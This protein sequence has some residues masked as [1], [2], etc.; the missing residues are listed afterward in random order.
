V[1]GGMGF[2]EETGAAQHMRDARVLAI[3]EGTNGIQANDLLFRKL[4]RDGGTAFGVYAK[5]MRETA[6]ALAA[7][8]GDDAKAIASRLNISLDHLEH[9]AKHLLHKAKEDIEVAALA[10]APF[11]RLF[12]VTA[13]GTQ[14]ARAAD[15]A[16]AGLAARA[17]ESGFL[18]AK[19]ITA[20][21]YAESVLPQTG[22]L[23]PVILSPQRGVLTLPAERF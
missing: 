2:V 4:A 17:G 13:G 6:A 10:A 22:G 14:M 20:R 11:L 9:A 15:V 19:L 5:E 3:Y 23:L 16:L 8:P 12:A 18:E 7:K 1:F 21:F